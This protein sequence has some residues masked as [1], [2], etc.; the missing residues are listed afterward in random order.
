ME[1][2]TS[3]MAERAPRRKRKVET[4]VQEGVHYEL[5]ELIEKVK[6]LPTGEWFPD[7]VT[8]LGPDGAPLLE[9]PSTKDGRTKPGVSR[10][11]F[12]SEHAEDGSPT[13]VV[14]STFFDP[15]LKEA[16]ADDVFTLEQ[17]IEKVSEVA[18]G[19]RVVLQGMPSRQPEPRVLE[20]TQETPLPSKDRQVISPDTTAFDVLTRSERIARIRELT[21]MSYLK[22]VRGIL[23]P[24]Y[25]HDDMSPKAI[26]I[27]SRL[28][29][30]LFEEVKKVGLLERLQALEAGKSEESTMRG[31]LL[32]Q[33]RAPRVGSAV[34]MPPKDPFDLVDTLVIRLFQKTQ[35]VGQGISLTEL[36][37]RHAAVV[38]A[39]VRQL[40]HS[41][42]THTRLRE[43]LQRLGIEQV[44]LEMT[45]WV[46]QAG[47]KE[48]RDVPLVGITVPKKETA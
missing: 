21:V 33:L 15:T 11:G 32:A 26:A 35:L 2:Y 40:E 16:F 14:V 18:Q 5:G 24:L 6:Q 41:E 25:T 19:N 38:A 10:F 42:G 4:V 20:D 45:V 8:I 46:E 34:G 43:E 39:I 1:W 47:E 48:R 22:Q 3:V 7:L 13:V 9:R 29:S 44:K 36:P 37:S 17:F 23:A 30:S 27:R 12:R 28:E 31:M